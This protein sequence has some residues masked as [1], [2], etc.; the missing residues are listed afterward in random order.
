M[1]TFW[2]FRLRFRRAWLNLQFRSS[3]GH[4]LS[5]DSD[6]DRLRCKWKPALNMGLVT[7]N[8]HWSTD[9]DLSSPIFPS[10]KLQTPFL[11]ILWYLHFAGNTRILPRDCTDYNK[12]YK[13]QPFLDWCFALC[14]TDQLEASGNTQ[15][16]W[17]GTFRSAVS[18]VS[19]FRFVYFRGS[20][21][22][23]FWVLV[24]ENVWKHYEHCFSRWVW[25][26]REQQQKRKVTDR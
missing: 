13:I 25:R 14:Q 6:Y 11:E 4:K 15:G 9:P 17:N 23:L 12:L 2:F 26:Y 20:F 18:L 5:Y 10:F 1:E 16:K 21:I 7:M 24:H 3:L 22:S 19:D 8:S